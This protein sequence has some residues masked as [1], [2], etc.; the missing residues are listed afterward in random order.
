VLA[1][2]IGDHLICPCILSANLTGPRNLRFLR[3]H[4]PQVLRVRGCFVVRTTT[5]LHE[6]A[7]ARFSLAAREG[8][9]RHSAGRC[10]GRGPEAPVSWPP[11][12][13][14]LDSIDFNC[15]VL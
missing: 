11:R 4:L 1:G 5:A 14:D 2:I 12:S 9:G 13:P 15:G 10:I 6:G 3:R 7:P 8:L